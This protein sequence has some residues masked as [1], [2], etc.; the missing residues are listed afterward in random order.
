MATTTPPQ[1]TSNVQPLPIWP[2]PVAAE[3]M[4]RLKTAK[5]KVDV[6]FKVL[7]RPAVVGS[8]GRVIAIGTMPDFPCEYAVINDHTNQAAYDAVMEWVLHPELIDDRASNEEDW[9]SYHFGVPVKFIEE[10][11]LRLERLAEHSKVYFK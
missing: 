8:P 6:P 5:A 11:D 1:T 9:L 10:V 7:P 3:D 2:W 4:D